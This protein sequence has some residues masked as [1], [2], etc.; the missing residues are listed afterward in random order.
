MDQR[1]KWKEMMRRKKSR[2]VVGKKLWKPEKNYL[3]NA[4]A[5]SLIWGVYQLTFFVQQ[6]ILQLVAKNN[7]HLLFPYDFEEVR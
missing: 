6:T 5:K 7:K 2:V 3:K 4:E 1:S